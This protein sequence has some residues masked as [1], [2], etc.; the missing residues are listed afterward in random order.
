MTSVVETLAA[1]MLPP[2]VLSVSPPASPT[3]CRP[4]HGTSALAAEGVGYRVGRHTLIES[5]DVAIVPGR[6][7]AVLGPNGAGKSS[8]LKILTGEVAPNKGR[9][10][11]NGVPYAAWP[12]EDVARQVAVLPQQST[13]SF[14]F[15][16]LEV[17]MMGRIP[18]ASGYTR[19]LEIARE[20]LDET[21][22][23]HMAERSFPMLSGGEQQRV[24]L[25]RVLAQVYTGAT[26]PLKQAR[27]L[28]LDEPTAALDP[29]HQQLTLE[30]ARRWAAQ[31]LGVLVILHDLNLAARYADQV[32]LLQQGRCIAQGETETVLKGSL[33]S[34]L[35]QLPL[36]VMDHPDRA[37]K[38]VVPC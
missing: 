19:D 14:P 38:L 37:H 15:T 6:V 11:L 34:D 13:L 36:R 25:A 24:Q 8:L 23:L 30:I 20:C 33:L 27:Y 4:V 22:C 21:G 31:G 35:Y 28:L 16:V 9:M 26:E 5:V 1:R 10:I 29:A 3:A 17:V 32:L 7:T 18:H 12:R 2:R